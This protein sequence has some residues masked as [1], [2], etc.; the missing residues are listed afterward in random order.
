MADREEVINMEIAMLVL[1]SV[2]VALQAVAIWLGR[3]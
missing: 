3:K 2:S 1:M